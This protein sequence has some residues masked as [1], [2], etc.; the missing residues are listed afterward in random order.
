[1]YRHWLIGIMIGCAAASV[2]C[3]FY[4][5]LCSA[6][7]RC[8]CDHVWGAR[9]AHC[10]IHNA[11]G[12]HCP[13][14]SFGQAGYG[15]L[16]G[17]V[18]LAQLLLGVFPRHWNWGKRLATALAAFPVLGGVEGASLGWITGYWN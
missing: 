9:E 16:F 7:Y 10:S 12:K 5:D 1:M 13:W 8:G 17:V 14:C 6:I 18:V 4:M 11:S 15:I 2:T 3:L